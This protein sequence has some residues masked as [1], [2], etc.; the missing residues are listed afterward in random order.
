MKTSKY[1]MLTACV[2][3]ILAI[4]LPVRAATAKSSGADGTPWTSWSLQVHQVDRGNV[5]LDYS[6]QMAI[7]ENLVEEVN[8]TGRFQQVFRDGDHGVSEI[9]NL[10]VLK[11]TVEQYTP[12]S[13]TRRAVTTVTGATKLTVRSQL[14]TRDGKVVV[15]RTVHG[16]VHF[17]GSNLRATHNLARNIAKA[18]EKTPLPDPATQ[19]VLAPNAVEPSTR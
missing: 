4:V 10:V 13:E 11:T 3:T 17:F 14:L 9:P 1:S 12:G 2:A 8:K 6:F 16:D 5:D 18:I 19:T 15:E 7:Y